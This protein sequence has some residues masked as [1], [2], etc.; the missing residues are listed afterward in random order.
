MRPLAV[1]GVPNEL[2]FVGRVGALGVLSGSALGRW[3]VA[4]ASRSLGPIFRMVALINPGLTPR[5]L[6]LPPERDLVGSLHDNV[7]PS[8]AG[9]FLCLCASGAVGGS[10]R[11]ADSS[12]NASCTWTFRLYPGPVSVVLGQRFFE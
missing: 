3:I 7:N 6:V 11:N 2:G 12:N 5:R 8:G 10:G 4:R 1:S 9:Q